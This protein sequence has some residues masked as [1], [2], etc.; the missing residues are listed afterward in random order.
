MGLIYARNFVAMYYSQTREDLYPEV[1]AVDMS[2]N[3]GDACSR[4]PVLRD[5]EGEQGTLVPKGRA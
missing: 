4:L 3:N 1:R 2:A 5:C